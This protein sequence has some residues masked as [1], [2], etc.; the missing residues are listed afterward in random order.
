MQENLQK[1]TDILVEQMSDW[2]KRL[3][4]QLK[5]ISVF[6]K[7]ED[8]DDEAQIKAMGG[9]T[10]EDDSPYSDEL[11]DI[12]H[13]ANKYSKKFACFKSTHLPKNRLDRPGVL[14]LLC[15]LSGRLWSMF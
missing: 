11:L 4:L 12:V 7:S 6:I 14:S 8:Y 9:L 15:S 13:S 2:E 3:S 1:N 5:S 10:F